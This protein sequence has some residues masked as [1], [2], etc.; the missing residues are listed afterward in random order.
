M[1]NYFKIN[2]NKAFTLIETLVATAVF[3]IIAVGIYAGFVSIL[4]TMNVIRVKGIMTN[5]ANEQF[6]IARNLS[7]QNVGTV[8]GIPSG[9]ILQSQTIDRDGKSFVVETVVRNVDEPFD[10]TFDGTPKDFSPADMKIIEVTISCSSCATSLS[11]VS[12][13]TKIAPK[14]LETASTNGALIVKVFDASGLPVVG[15]DVNIINNSISPAVNLNDQTDING[16]LTIV[17]A[18]PSVSGYQIA[19]TKDGYSTDRT[20]PVGDSSNPNPTKP[21][22]TVVLQQ[23]SQISFTIDKVSTINISTVNNQCVITPNFDFS[24]SGNK[25]IGTT[26]DTYKYSRTFETNTVG[27]KTLSD[28]EWD[29]YMI[30]GI[31]GTYDIIGTSPL[32]SLGINPD[33]EQDMQIITAPK[34]GKRLLVVIRDQST[35]LPV[36]DAVVALTGPNDYSHTNITNEGFLIQTDWSGGGGQADFTDSTKYLDS[37]SNINDSISPGNLSLNNIFGNYVS[38]GYITSSTFDTGSISN[39]KQIMWNSITQPPQTGTSSVRVQI[40]TNNDNLTWNFVGPDGTPSSY[41]TSSNQNMSSSHS[42]NRYIRYRLYLSTQDTS[43]TPTISDVSIAYTSSCIPPGQVSF[44]ALS[45]GTYTIYVE[46]A[47]YQ[48]ISKQVNIASSWQ[49]E[50]IIISP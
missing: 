11:S 3:L 38:S 37:D 27:E 22:V 1:R 9:V 15:A 32:L 42:G 45:T 14:N 18:P 50:E 12:F 46:K 5:I 44:T 8:N 41:Y 49:K 10:G 28:I 47:G 48:D 26:P 36:T 19:V 16:M 40:A 20:Y 39:F 31:D 6:E 34:N 23:I 35:G 30:S 24:I 21:N 25:L 17:D 33:V 7:Y 43:Y 29:T 2:K 13:T 4:K